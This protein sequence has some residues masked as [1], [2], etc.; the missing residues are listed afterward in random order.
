MVVEEKSS[1]SLKENQANNDAVPIE[2]KTYSL[3]ILRIIK[4]AQ[5]QHGLRHSDYQRY[6]GYCS[7]RIRRLRKVLKAPQGDKRHFKRRDITASMVTDDKFLQIPLMIAERAWSYAMQL[8]QESNTEPRK[9]FH[10]IS[11]LRKAATYSLQLQELIE[12]I[13]CDARTKL[14]AQAYVAWIHGSLHFE[15]QLWKKAM[16]NL[17][18]AQVVYG[19]LASALPE[20]E[21]MIYNARVEEL[22]PS[23]RYCAYNIGDTTAID[24][25]M[26]MRG[27]LSGELLASLDSLI[28][29]TREKQT[30]T[31]EV[32]WRG[33]SCGVVPPRAAGL[34][35]ADSR[36]NQT[37]E[38]AATNQAKIDLLE[39]H[40]IDCKDAISVVRDFYKNELKNKDSDKPSPSQHLITYLQYI[41]LSRTLERNLTLIKVAEESAKA[42]PQD[43]VRLYEA[44]LHNL[45][46]ISQLQDDEE[47]ARE[48][49]AKTKAY[50]AFRCYYLAQS[51]ANLHRWR[52][53]MALYQRSGQHM[54]DALKYGAVLPESLR[55]ALQTLETAIEGAKYAAHAHSVLEDEQEEEPESNKYTKTKKPLYE[56]LQEY[57][58]DNALLTK[59]PNVYKLPPAMQPIPCKPL[60]FDLAFNMIEFPDLSEKLGD[61]AK[62]GGQA[63][64][65]GFVK[66]LW[67]WGNK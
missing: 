18:K 42:K 58:E 45:V 1:E 4:E 62:K 63:G 54:N 56:R 21:Q 64:L 25:L 27:Q 37:L 52:E 53:A 32:T 23:L 31:E 51:L 35:I 46:E 34:L 9:K 20:L 28:A 38:K 44:A 17:K 33:K 41:R 22:A 7:R 67:G 2:Q 5:Q 50:R 61:Q 14:E 15:L 13:N 29:Q 10:L 57:R 6:R 26:Q 59:Q 16:E 11:R 12:A 39:A 36:L 19:K 40:L 3:E 8:R 30:N 48:Q 65:T 55:E 66:G 60:F 24:D 43:I 49:E 47:F